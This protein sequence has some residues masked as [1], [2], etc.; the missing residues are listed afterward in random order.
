MEKAGLSGRPRATWRLQ[1]I[2]S[3]SVLK[4]LSIPINLGSLGLPLVKSILTRG[5]DVW[6]YIYLGIIVR[7]HGLAFGLR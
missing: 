7:N 6:I 4:S 3:V 1:F 5:V 2:R